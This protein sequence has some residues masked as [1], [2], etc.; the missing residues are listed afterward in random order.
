MS[1]MV[2]ATIGSGRLPARSAAVSA[3]A[4]SANI[5][6]PYRSAAPCTRLGS[7]R[8]AHGAAYT[9]RCGDGRLQHDADVV[10]RHPDPLVAVPGPVTGVP[11]VAGAEP[12]VLGDAT[13]AVAVVPVVRA[14]VADDHRAV[15]AVVRAVEAAGIRHPSHTEQRERE[16]SRRDEATHG[17]CPF[18]FE[19]T[20]EHRPCRPGPRVATPTCNNE[21]ASTCTFRRTVCRV[22]KVPRAHAPPV[23]SEG[24]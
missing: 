20:Q 1:V 14:A 16:S 23:S 2:S 7:L 24:A 5:A 12:V 4:S 17:V 10:A 13:G 6:A 8:R 9:Y 19:Q 21:H 18:R 22:R 11:V 15:A 3:T